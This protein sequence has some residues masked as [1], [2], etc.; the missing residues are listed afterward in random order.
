M[1]LVGAVTLGM[2]VATFGWEWVAVHRAK[3]QASNTYEPSKIVAGVPGQVERNDGQ[4]LLI[5]QCPRD[6]QD[7]L[8]GL[9]TPGSFDQRVGVVAKGC[10]LDWVV[11]P[12]DTSSLPGQVVI[13]GGPAD[14]GKPLI[15]HT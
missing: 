10:I 3:Q 14:V 12:G 6:T 5:E 1:L 2:D 15:A 9:P 7:T 13:F 4:R 8:T 11:D